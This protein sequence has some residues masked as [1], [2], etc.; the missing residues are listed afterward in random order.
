[1]TGHLRAIALVSFAT[2]AACV[3]ATEDERAMTGALTGAALGA[4][5]AKALENDSD[6]VII[7]ALAGAAV[8]TLV[9]RNQATRECAYAQGD[10]TYY[11]RPCP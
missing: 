9:A 1:M 5:T 6:W 2:L 11:V 8:G 4:L 10:G 3:G 7:G